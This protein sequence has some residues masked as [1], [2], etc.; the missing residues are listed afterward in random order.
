MTWVCAIHP[1]E[2]PDEGEN[3]HGVPWAEFKQT[4]ERFCG[5]SE[6]KLHED[7]GFVNMTPA[8]LDSWETDECADQKSL[9]PQL[10]RDRVRKPATTHPRD[11][12]SHGD[13]GM[14]DPEQ[15]GHL[16]IANKVVSYNARGYG[17]WKLYGAYKQFGGVSH[18]CPSGW[19]IADL[20]WQQDPER[21]YAGEFYDPDDGRQRQVDIREDLRG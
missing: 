2:L 20:N 16:E 6:G 19:G 21:V 17:S 3:R 12:A 10:V 7:G 11:W 8:E 1:D 9:E 4:V 14:D 13:S 18:R 5:F 15:M